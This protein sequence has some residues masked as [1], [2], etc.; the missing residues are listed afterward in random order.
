MARLYADENFDYPVVLELRNLGHDVLTAQEAGQANQGI[1]DAAV[2]TYATSLSRAVLT[3][4]H[5]HFRRLHSIQQ[6]H[7]GI[8]SCTH[9]D[10]VVALGQR[11][12]HA[13]SNL[14]TLD[15][16]FLRIVRPAKP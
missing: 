9:D 10:D 6:P 3:F 15:N 16:Q 1:A 5:R 2:L 11:I 12:H 8:I 7:A 4:N 13:V 14:A